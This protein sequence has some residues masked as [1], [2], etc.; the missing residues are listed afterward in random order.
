MAGR[1]GVTDDIDRVAAVERA[2]NGGLHAVGGVQARD[3]ELAH[4]MIGKPRVER[5]IAKRVGLGLGDFDE[6]WCAREAG[7]EL[8]PRCSGH[9]GGPG[10]QSMEPII[11]HGHPDQK[12]R[13]TAR[14]RGF[15]QLVGARHDAGSFRVG[16]FGLGSRVVLLQ[17][18]ENESLAR[19][20]G[21][22]GRALGGTDRAPNR[23]AQGRAAKNEQGGNRDQDSLHGLHS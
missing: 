8:G 4:A 11:R 16:L 6:I 15:D 22:N 12:H 21:V 2:S 19:P 1:D 17:I 13:P 20:V 14:A 23:E 9:C 18:H 7:V 3:V 5:R 10:H